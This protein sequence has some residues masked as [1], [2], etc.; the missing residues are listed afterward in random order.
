VTDPGVIQWQDFA[1][2]LQCAG[3]IVRVDE[4]PEAHKPAYKVHAD[5]GPYGVRKSSAQIATKYTRKE[6]VGRQIIGVLN[7]PP[8]QVGPFM[9]EFLVTG[10]VLEDGSVVLAQPEQNVPN[11]TRLA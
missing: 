6:L 3:T 2:V 8:K 11:G 4:F 5:F 7:F 1:R 9:S 10:F